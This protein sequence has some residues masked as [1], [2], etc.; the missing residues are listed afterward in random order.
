[1]AT[2]TPSEHPPLVLPL[3][4][5]RG[6]FERI[7]RY[8]YERSMARKGTE[9]L[10]AHMMAR[11][12]E[13]STALGFGVRRVVAGTLLAGVAA[14]SLFVVDQRTGGESGEGRQVVGSS[15]GPNVE[16]IVRHEVEISSDCDVPALV[17]SVLHNFE[18]ATVLEDSH[19]T[20]QETLVV[21]ERC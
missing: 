18:N 2:I 10:E 14:A 7:G 20:G 15:A 17:D 1:M 9:A 5:K 11:Q 19:V 6:Y 3:T 13:K 21:P 8:A 12:I 16:A 4:P